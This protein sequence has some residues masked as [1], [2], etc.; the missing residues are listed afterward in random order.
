MTLNDSEGHKINVHAKGLDL[1]S[2]GS[3]YHQNQTYA[4]GDTERE[5]VHFERN[6]KTFVLLLTFLL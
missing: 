4:H 6:L 2:M 1:N 5:F 3:D